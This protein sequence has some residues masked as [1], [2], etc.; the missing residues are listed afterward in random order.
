[1]KKFLSFVVLVALVF[2]FV[3]CDDASIDMSNYTIDY[4]DAATFESVLND[5][6][7]VN[8]KI[9]QFSVNDYVPDSILGINCHAGEHLNF[10]FE[11]EL[12]VEKGDIVVVHITEAPTKIFLT[13]SWKI[14]CEVL[15]IKESNEEITTDITLETTSNSNVEADVESSSADVEKITVTMSEEE[16]K[17]MP[18]A[19]AEKKLREMGF[20]IFEYDTLNAG[21]RSD[22]DGKIGAVEIKSWT[23]G[24]GD[25]SKGDVYDNDAIV[26]LWSYEY[27]ETEA[28]SPVFY[29]TNDYETAK[30]GSSGVFS[31][32]NKTGSYDVYWIIDFDAGYVYFFTDNNGEDFCD[33]VKIVSGH[34]NDKVTIIWDDE[35]SPW[36]L[37]FKY[38]NSPVTLVVNDHLGITTEF[39]TTD[40]DDA[41]R[42]RDTKNIIGY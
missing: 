42:I 39:T 29:S 13:S 30:E 4:D 9:V 25:F 28:S 32:K 3:G 38:V 31:Y 15:E 5:G 20:T 27:T 40:L 22:L 41:I 33:K 18:T 26:V 11:S 35:T 21:D 37:H 36:Y 2:A 16:F 12:V 23:F 8:G 7:N 1:M 17:K 19:D 6:G 34:L 24:K 14:P 10:I